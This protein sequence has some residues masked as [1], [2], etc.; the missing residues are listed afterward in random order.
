MVVFAPYAIN[1]MSLN[2]LHQAT[3]WLTLSSSNNVL[4]SRET[5]VLQ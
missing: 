5:Y 4:I 2:E 1:F 3:V